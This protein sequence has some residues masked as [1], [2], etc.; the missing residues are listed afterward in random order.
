MKTK[1]F[2]VGVIVLAILLVFVGVRYSDKILPEGGTVT[3]DTQSR[4]EITTKEGHTTVKPFVE[5]Q[6]QI[7]ANEATV[8]T[9]SESKEQHTAKLVSGDTRVWPK[10]EVLKG[11]P[12][13]DSSRITTSL[14]YETAYGK[15]FIIR[16]EEF[17]YGEFLE[18]VS[19]LEDAGFADKN[20][21]YHI[22]EA[23]PTGTAMFYY[24]FDGERSFGVYW[25]GTQ[26]PAGFD[27]EIVVCDYDQAK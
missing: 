23:E 3:Q 27:C 5:A 24:S 10:A 8:P 26:S 18:Y 22:P 2:I 14:E 9:E 1:I 21:R 13:P 12:K 19:R 20:N 25:H 16:F 17:G 7:I 11:I 15:Q 4:H 6:T